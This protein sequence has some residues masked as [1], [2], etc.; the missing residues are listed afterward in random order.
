MPRITKKY[1]IVR[2][3]GRTTRRDPKSI[4]GG[5]KTIQA[6][7]LVNRLSFSSARIGKL[8]D[9]GNK[10]RD[11]Y[12]IDHTRRG[13]HKTEKCIQG[14]SQNFHTKLWLQPPPTTLVLIR[15]RGDMSGEDMFGERL[16]RKRASHHLVRLSLS[17]TQQNGPEQT[18]FCR[19]L[20]VVI[21]SSRVINQSRFVSNWYRQKYR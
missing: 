10:S 5:N 21:Q 15:R 4:A 11:L 12:T 18:S 3:A 19:S 1:Q 7:A 16:S 6:F 14:N 20:A 8:R 2:L 13:H 9:S 17:T